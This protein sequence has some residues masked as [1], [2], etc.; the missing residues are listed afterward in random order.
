MN[1]LHWIISNCRVTQAE[2]KYEV[3]GEVTTKVVSS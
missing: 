2:G 3:F 1:V